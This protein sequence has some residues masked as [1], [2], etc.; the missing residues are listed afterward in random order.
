M[1]LK[2]PESIQLP[3]HT[4]H[5][6][7]HSSQCRCNY[8]ELPLYELKAHSLFKHF[9]FSASVTYALYILVLCIHCRIVYPAMYIHTWVFSSYF[10]IFY[11]YLYSNVFQLNKTWRCLIWKKE[12]KPT[13]FKIYRTNLFTVFVTRYPPLAPN[14]DVSHPASSRH[15]YFAD[16]KKNNLCTIILTRDISTTTI[17]G[18]VVLHLL[19]ECLFAVLSFCLFACCLQM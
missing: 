18:S 2:H 6:Y 1:K 4:F 3:L 13:E 7:I 12:E 16:K 14:F 8:S 9:H 19:C 11:G 17:L 5:S 15:I 10:H